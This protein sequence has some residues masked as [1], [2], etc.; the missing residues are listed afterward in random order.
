MKIKKTFLGKTD[1]GRK[2]QINEDSFFCSEKDSL[3][4]VAD[5]MGGH[6]FG[7]IASKMAVESIRDYVRDHIQPL[8]HEI[9][10]QE[11]LFS[12]LTQE[13][14]RAAMEANEKIFG[15]LKKEDRGKPMGTTLVLAYFLQKYVFFVHVGDSRGYIFR[16]GRLKR[17]TEDHTV[18]NRWLQVGQISQEQAL[19]Y[20]KTSNSR[21]VTRALGTKP[22][23]RADI[24]IHP[25]VHNDLF[26][27]CSDGLT[28]LL[29]DE[30]IE[31]ILLDGEGHL[32]RMAKKL[33]SMANGRG[34][35]DNITVVFAHIQDLEAK[36]G[37]ETEVFQRMI[38]EESD[39]EIFVRNQD[40]SFSRKKPGHSV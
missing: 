5:G 40:G 31:E 24:T 22:T 27:L 11:A 25:I 39:T 17:L 8:T 4:I 3:C 2:R 10:N 15:C 37:E 34:G 7:E 19:Q 20:K 18:I 9:Q 26:L 38:Q 12:K 33:I 29:D 32:S 36:Q 6:S 16:N 1:V 21:F 23:I 13:F 35:K 28:D 14:Q 30:E